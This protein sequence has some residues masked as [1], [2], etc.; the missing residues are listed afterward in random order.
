[1]LHV[2]AALYIKIFN[3]AYGRLLIYPC[4]LIGRRSLSNARSSG[5][6]KGISGALYRFIYQEIGLRLEMLEDE[7]MVV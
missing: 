4:R 7:S 5:H 3:T 1:V 2:S 6:F